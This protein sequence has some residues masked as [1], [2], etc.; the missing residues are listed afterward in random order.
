MLEVSLLE[1][2]YLPQR[3]IDYSSSFI[4]AAPYIGMARSDAAHAVDYHPI[5]NSRA[6]REAVLKRLFDI[7]FALTFLIVA[8]PI[9]IILSIT[10]QID[11][12][13]R[14]FFVQP[15]VGRHDRMFNCFKF[16][17][18]HEDAEALLAGLLAQSPEAR[19]EW[20]ADHKLRNDPRVSRLGRIIRKLSL[21]E[22]PQLFNILAGEMSVVGPR[23]IV[24]AEVPK[25]GTYFPDY[26]AVKPGLTGLWQ[27]SGRNDVTYD[28]RVQLDCQYR[29]NASFTFDMSIVLKTIPAVL[30]AK[31]SY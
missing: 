18:M 31:G 13:G 3:D 20:D 9:L 30:G 14:L 1:Q 19:R 24:R 8:L 27:V 22:L 29:R 4:I 5:A 12:P 21:D 10:L 25:Y 17:T 15:R 26:C 6:E 7:C 2:R 23:P 28:E 16:R 11:S